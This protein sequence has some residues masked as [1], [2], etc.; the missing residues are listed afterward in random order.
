MFA[1]LARAVQ[2]L[3]APPA[4]AK[5]RTG[6]VA[7]GYSTSGGIPDLDYLE[8]LAFPDYLEEFKRVANDAEVA[9][10]IRETTQPIINADWCVEPA[11]EDARDVLIA[12]F[13]AASRYNQ[14]GETYGVEFWPET[15]WEDRL[16][17][18]LRFLVNGFSVFQHIYR[19]QGRYTVLHKMK[20][21][22]PLSIARFKPGPEPDTFEGIIR[23]Y[24]RWDGEAA[25][26]ELVPMGDL[27]FYTWDQ[28][29]SNILGKSIMRSWWMAYQFKIKLMK[30]MMIDKQRTSIGIPYYKHPVGDTV[31]NIARGEKVTKA[32][33]AGALERLY[34]GGMTEGQDFGWKEGG[35]STKG[36]PDLIGMMDGQIRGGGGM[37]FTSLGDNQGDAGGSRGVAG[38]QAAFS[39]LLLEGIAKTII[40]YERPGIRRDVD[41]NFPGVKRHPTLKCK[42]IDPFEKTRVQG[43]IVNAITGKALTNTIDTE[44]ELRR[45]WNLM[46]IDEAERRQAQAME[47]ASTDGSGQGDPN[48]DPNKPAP[49]DDTATGGEDVPE[50]VTNAR[51]LIRLQEQDDVI[52]RA[53]VDAGAIQRELE[54]LEAVYLATLSNVQDDMREAV[55]DQIRAGALRPV[56]A[57]QVKV[58]FQHELKERLVAICKTVRD[59]GRKQVIAEV[60]RQ[61]QSLQRTAMPDP[62]TRRGAITYSN[63]QAEVVAGLDVSNLVQRLQSQVTAQWNQLVGT[64]KDPAEIAGQIQAY[65]GDLST[66]QIEGMARAS[67]STVFNAGRNVA[68]LELRPQL[69]PEAI[70]VEVLDENTCKPCGTPASEGGL[71]LL[72]TKIGSAEYLENQP[73]HGCEGGV[74]CRGF[75]VVNAR[76]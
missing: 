64:G 23:N 60:N 62:S 59:Y 76:V 21:L 19:S 49:G 61:L 45:G 71:N 50:P 68:I 74:R 66:Q 36:F 41:M 53:R 43:E 54:R 15:Y 73:P 25:T 55:V 65:L 44:N 28:E 4:R 24:T 67:T 26:E 31:E 7:S 40:R 16:R 39:T 57:K 2:S 3:A 12:E 38:T 51:G 17:D 35:Q 56:D 27:T 18:A 32:M 47:P 69:Q 5:V 42:G 20:Y 37:G 70:R 11:S 34:V 30:L 63:Q 10:V 9:K 33:R 29:G 46:E 1:G 14:E 72:R 52:V 48:A 22:Q 75:Y 13:I 58:P 6:E 8:E